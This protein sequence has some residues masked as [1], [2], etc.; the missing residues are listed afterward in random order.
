MDEEIQLPIDL[1]KSPAEYFQAA[2]A[3][4]KEITAMIFTPEQEARLLIEAGKTCDLSGE[5]NQA[6]ENYQC[7]LNVCESD[8]TKAEALKQTGHIKSKMSE[9]EVALESYEASLEILNRLGNLR[10]VGNIQNCV[11][12]NYFMTGNITRANEYYNKALEIGKQCEDAQLLSDVHISLG[13]LSNVKGQYDEAI[14]HYQQSTARYK[15]IGDNHGLSQVY[16]NL[17]MTYIGNK[18]WELAGEYFQKSIELCIELG[19]TD[20]LSIIYTN[21][22]RLALHLHDPY[23]SKVYCDKA[24][25]IFDGTGNKMGIA[26]VYKL[27]GT[28]Y[29][30]MQKWSS[31]ESAFQRGIGICDEYENDLTKAEIYYELGLMRNKQSK[32]EL[33]LTDLQKSVEIYEKL[34]IHGEINKI[35]TEIQ[36]IEE[37]QGNI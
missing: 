34:G 33:A 26:E 9:W 25:V 14:T 19:N 32:K 13:I 31:A 21:R 6:L 36:T 16:H 23:M 28:I 1:R 11:G 29:S 17:A 37:C 5:W 20:L 10:E 30:N 22:A 12:Y 27:Y 8:E 3:K 35:R 2:L 15:V 4:V 24:Y 18:S 7:A